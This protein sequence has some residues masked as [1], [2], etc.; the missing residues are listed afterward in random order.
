[1]EWMFDERKMKAAFKA[2]YVEMKSDCFVCALHIPPQ[3]KNVPPRRFSIFSC[4]LFF[5][6]GKVQTFVL[7]II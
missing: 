5:N 3:K 1:M 2:K 4:G 7:N 6:A